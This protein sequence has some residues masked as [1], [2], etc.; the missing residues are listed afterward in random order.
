[1]K[2]EAL[3]NEIE[4]PL[5]ERNFAHVLTALAFAG[6]ADSAEELNS[7]PCCWWTE[8]HF[9][10]R[11]S[12]SR[13]Q[14]FTEAH[15]LAKSIRWTDGIGCD[16]KKQV[17]A[18]PHHGLFTAAGFDGI[19]PLLNY[20]D[21]GISSSVFKAFSGRLNPG[22]LLRKQIAELKAV[23]ETPDWLFQQGKGVASWKFDCRVAG[24]AYDQGFS[25]DAEGSGDATPFYP[26]IEL[27][28][29]AGA[30]FFA[31]PHAWLASEESLSY[32]IWQESVSLHLAPLAAA[33]LIEGVGGRRYGLATRGNA[34][35]KGAAYRHFPEANPIL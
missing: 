30:T 23:G 33:D 9:K 7:D 32:C 27:L 18:S 25:A 10:L 20:E 12:R 4:L 5:D 3:M 26:A 16:E 34:Y 15:A 17:K 29:I 6:I 21:G 14:L 31:S 8:G 1:M 11:V 13:E 19:N 28:S 24:H 22:G 35:G 2:T